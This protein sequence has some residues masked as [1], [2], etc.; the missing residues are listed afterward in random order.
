MAAFA[1]DGTGITVPRLADARARIVELWREHFG[2][3]ADTRTGSTDG[4]VIDM[5]A[6]LLALLWQGLGSSVSNAYGRTAER[7]FLDRIL[8][9]FARQRIP[10]R[11][12]T[13]SAVFYGTDATVVGLGS[14][15]QVGDDPDAARFATDAAATIGDGDLAHVV[16]INAIEDSTLYTITVDA[17]ACDFTTGVSATRAE[18]VEGLIASLD[19]E[20]FVGLDGGDDVD[21]RPRIVIESAAASTVTV[22]ANLTAYD[23]VRVAATATATGPTVMLAGDARMAVAISGVVDVATTADA[24]VGRARETDAEFWSRHLSTL[25]RNG[26]RTPDATE[27]RLLELAGVEAARLIENETPATDADGRPAHS[28]E[29]IVLGG[30]SAEI[31]AL[32]AAHKPWGI[33]SW[34]QTE[35][36]NVPVG[37]HGSVVG[38]GITR[39]TEL[40]L[41]LEITVTE[42][43]GWPSSG[44]PRETILAAVA[45]YLGQAPGKPT[46]G[47]NLY[48]AQLFAPV[49]GAVSG[50]ATVSIRT[51]TTAAPGDVPTYAAADIVVD[52]DEILRADST[53]ITVL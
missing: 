23:A 19:A 46:M 47:S 30:N 25:S 42:G 20:G 13:A 1:I 44:T 37:R 49:T 52:D 14:L 50:V 17:T 21:E 18:L 24:T 43:E 39:P 6:L 22:G 35:T 38:I 32:I 29:P 36:I 11:A 2:S 28:F 27:D 34:G 4:E 53:R 40:Y 15:V 8:D 48:R 5:L 26:T 7:N 10:A 3:S 12:T 16:R 9:L 31:A 41:H 33:R 51:A 45:T